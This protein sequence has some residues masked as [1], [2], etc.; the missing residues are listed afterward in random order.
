MLSLFTRYPLVIHWLSVRITLRPECPGVGCSAD[1][2]IAISSSDYPV[3]D[4]LAVIEFHSG[5]MVAADCN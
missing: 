4:W 3:L 5:V 2:W 1:D